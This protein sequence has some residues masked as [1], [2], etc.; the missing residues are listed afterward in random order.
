VVEHVTQSTQAPVR[1]SVDA[2]LNTPMPAAAT[3]W[4]DADF[5]AIDLETTGLDPATDEIIAFATVPITCGRVHLREAD[6]RLVRPRR[7][8]EAETIRIHGLR[9]EDLAGAPALTEV[10]DQLLDALTGKALVVHVATVENG[11]LRP[12]LEQAGAELRNPVIDTAEL[13]AELFRLRR[14]PR[15]ERIGLTPLARTLGLPVHR[16][17]EADGDALTT[18]QVFLALATQLEAIEP[19]T[20]GSLC[21]LRHRSGPGP[22]RRALRRLRSG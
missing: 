11:F 15:P 4:R 8:P 1:S 13:A 20:I 6:Y 9:S 16:P 17:H 3:P 12:V 18:A 22:L 10:L 5:C 21:E 14:E 19:Q 2:Y 7:M